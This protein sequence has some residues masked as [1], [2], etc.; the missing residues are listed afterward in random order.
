MSPSAPTAALPSAAASAGTAVR[1]TAFWSAVALPFAVI[2]LLLVGVPL[3]WVG[4][5]LAC[6]AGALLVGHSHRADRPAHDRRRG[7]P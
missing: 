7:R 3:P 4:L 6:N 1:A 2:G 5:L